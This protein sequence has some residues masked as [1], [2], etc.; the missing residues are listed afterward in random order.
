MPDLL[1]QLG[2]L[3]TLALGI[4]G[5]VAPAKASEWVEISARTHP[6]PAEFRAIYGGLFVALG[7]VPL[8]TGADAA[9]LTTGLAWVSA[10]SG[11]V[12]SIFLD[13]SLDPRNW[14][15]V[16]FEGGLGALCLLALL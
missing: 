14:L 13:R 8:V 7:L 2:A 15:A 4:L 12:V 11:R 3:I 16:G 6:G 10:A 9:Y 1:A 5:V